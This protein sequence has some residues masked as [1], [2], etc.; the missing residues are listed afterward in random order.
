MADQ[1]ETRGATGPEEQNG[2]ALVIA[3]ILLA[4]ILWLVA[5]RRQA[6]APKPADAPAAEFSGARALGVLRDLLGDGSPHPTGSPANAAVRD[7]IVAQLRALGYSPEVQADFACGPMNNT[8]ARVENVVARLEG[9]ARDGAVLLMSHYDSVPAG[10]GAGD[11]MS[12]VAAMLEVARAF[13]NGPPPKNPVILLFTDGEELGLVGAKAF[14][15]SP[16]SREVKVVVNLEA[17][18]SSGPSLMFESIGDNGWLIPLLA[19]GAPHPVTSSVYVTIYE[20]MPNNTDL[21]VFKGRGVHGLNFA[22]LENPMHYHTSADSLEN[23]SPASLQH[24][25][26]NAL[27]VV[28]QLAQADLANPPAGK[29]VFFDVLGWSVVRWPVG[30]TV[31]LA[32]LTLL[33]MVSVFVV[34]MRRRR[35]SFGGLVFGLLAFLG[36]V[37]L[38]GALAYGLAMVVGNALQVPWI[39]RPFPL[40]AAFWLL[41]LVVAGLLLPWLARRAA[42]GGAYVGVWLAWSLAGLALAFVAPGI[43]YLFLVPALIAGVAGHAYLQGGSPTTGAVAV[44]L[45]VLIAGIL[46]FAILIPLYAGL[47]ST[48]L[49]VISVLLSMLVAAL[50]PLYAVTRPRVRWAVTGLALAGVIVGLAVALTSPSYAASSP[51]ALSIQ[52]HLEADS[53]RSRW[54]VFNAPPFPQE[55]RQGAEFGAERETTYP[56][57]TFRSW[58]APAPRLEQPG[59][60]LAVLEDVPAGNGRQVR[61]LLTSDR[62]APVALLMIPRSAKL[63]SMSIDGRPVDLGSVPRMGGPR[64]GGGQPPEY[65]GVQ[66]MTLP[67]DGAE[68]V[69]LLGERAPQEWYVSDRTYGL[70]P[71]ADALQ[72][73]RPPATVRSQDGDTTLVTRKVRI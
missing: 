10:P 9:T 17:R 37:L 71:F 65:R 24:H 38:T 73:V 44:L 34:A 23:L 52:Y 69:L 25:G 29:A 55:L 48:A 42:P 14:V 70:P 46:W 3:L 27:G 8:C 54:L 61:A 16:Q 7:R 19:G 31:P 15:D 26:D 41:P 64:G 2:W 13:K 36:S 35:A 72:K 47:G 62:G 56:W 1:I 22:F 68:I 67:P 66:I 50:A 11:A 32:V 63:E 6:P 53:G 59:P 45:P 21:T 28:R 20:M 49:L 58:Q 51:Q 40:L 43:S 60:N 30:W 18:G 57:G 12:G 5:V 4:L 39:A 33:V